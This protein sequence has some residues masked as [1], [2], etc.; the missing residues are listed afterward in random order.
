LSKIIFFLQLGGVVDEGL[1][2]AAAAAVELLDDL[3]DKE[4]SQQI[5]SLK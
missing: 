2:A 3:I 5:T 4:I 1:G